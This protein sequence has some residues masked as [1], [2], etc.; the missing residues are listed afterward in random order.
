MKKKI[1][2]I[3]DKYIGGDYPILV[4]SMTNTKTSDFD[5]TA[6][7]IKE[8]IFHGVDLVRVSIF[9]DDD[10]LGLEKLI[11]YFEIPIIA[12][13]HFNSNY[14][15]K[16]INA[17]A[18]KIRLNPGNIK[19]E[20]QI[21]EIIN[22][23]KSKNI[24]I[25]IGVNSGSIP[26]DLLDNNKVTPDVMLKTLDRYLEI[27]ESKEFD[28]IVISL[29]SHD[30]LINK[31]VNEIAHEKY[32]YPIHA[33][34]TESGPMIS[35]L[36]KSTLGLSGLI[37][38]NII[39]TM[40]ISLTD[41]PNLEVI[42]AIKLLN[43]LKKRNDRVDIISCPTCGR[44]EAD[45]FSIVN[46]IE[47]YCSNLFFPLTISI[48]GCVVNGIGEGKQSDIGI[49]CSKQKA[50]LF[51]NGKFLKNIDISDAINELKELIDK[52]Y[53]LYKGIL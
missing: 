13:I 40:R 5:A 30:Y 1:I 14:A 20:K 49:A 17:G 53:L 44:L 16:A 9:D 41:D 35:G 48:L 29:K 51:E 26:D 47:K 43:I 45:L 25:R 38:K 23:A 19:S 28:N 42:A 34:V 46:E 15:I 10:I 8:M 24:P 4:Q 22:L 3:K 33:G 27:F 52:K 31:K 6:K 12:D 39:N 50:I 32:I 2:K 7:Q 11:K 21:I 36:I 18:H 37:E